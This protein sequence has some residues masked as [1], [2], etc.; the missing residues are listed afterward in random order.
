MNKEIQASSKGHDSEEDA[1]ACVDLLR[2]KMANGPD[3]GSFMDTAESIFERM[4]RYVTD[5]TTN[6]TR[7]TAFCD[8]GNPRSGMGGKATSVARCTTDDEVIDNMVTYSDDHHFVFGRLMELAHVQGCGSFCLGI[9]EANT[10][11]R[12]DPRRIK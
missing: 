2:L 3:F 7:R 11:G 9:F 6:E 5:A 1:R 8:Y 10:R 12:Q 4:N